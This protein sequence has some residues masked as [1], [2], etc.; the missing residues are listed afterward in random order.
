[1]LLSGSDTAVSVTRSYHLPKGKEPR[2]RN[3]SKSESTQLIDRL[4]GS[5]CESNAP[6]TRKLAARRS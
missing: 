6:A 3:A 2:S 4:R 5:V 1:M